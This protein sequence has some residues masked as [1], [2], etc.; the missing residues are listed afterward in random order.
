ML[1][2]VLRHNL[3]LVRAQLSRCRVIPCMV[4]QLP[5]P[6]KIDV[7]GG[8]RSFAIVD[9]ADNVGDISRVIELLNRGLK[10]LHFR[11][12]FSDLSISIRILSNIL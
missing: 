2:I 4:P 9:N 8:T 7:A 6:L 1:H 5:H 12:D 3:R 10:L 11:V